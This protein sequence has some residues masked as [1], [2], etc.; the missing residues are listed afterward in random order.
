M[1]L[2]RGLKV[3]KLIIA[4]GF[5]IVVSGGAQAILA[6]TISGFVYA[7]GRRA[8][9][10]VDVELQ[11]ENRITLQRFRTNSA[12][13]YSFTINR[14][15]RFYVRV[16]PFR[17]NLIDQTQEVILQ[18]LSQTGQGSVDVQQDFYL[19]RKKGGLG[20]TT[21][22]VFFAQEVPKDAEDL[23]KAG[24]KDFSN[25]KSSPGMTKMVKAI[26]IFPTYYAASQ[27]LGIELLKTKQF[28]DAAKLFMRAAEVN[29]K[30]SRSFYYTGFSLN[31]LG[32]KYNTAALKALEKAT[33]L[34]PASWEV[35]FL[36]GKIQRE[37]GNYIEAEKFLLKS[38]KLARVKNPSIHIELAQLYAND[39]KKFGKAADELE[40]YLKSSGKKDP[41]IKQQIADLR[42]KSKGDD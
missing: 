41:K 7:P 4:V 22:G 17:Y 8:V 25:K 13:R 27:R 16:L 31:K 14:D 11:D 23:Y 24:M 10:E 1:V 39:L 18:T 12:G 9:D 35:A 36:V 3:F 29:P 28:L 40:L 30:S 37:D 34:A 33:V 2:L 21:T 5:L 42:N 38:K 6:S 19:K 26:N 20:D 32:K 15:G